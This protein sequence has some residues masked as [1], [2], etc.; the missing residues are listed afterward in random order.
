MTT[1]V[2]A[3]DRR[4]VL[5]IL[6]SMLK[7]QGFVV[8]VAADGRNVLDICSREQVDAVIMDMNMP[9]MDG[10]EATET[11]KASKATQSIPVIICTAHALPWDRK[12]AMECGCNAFMD[13]PVRLEELLKLLRHLLSEAA[14]KT[15]DSHDRD[16]ADDTTVLVHANRGV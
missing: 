3:D 12:R 13:K 16:G 9:E 1:I 8:K 10:C 5:T 14:A 4:D 2:V 6:E 15:G 11:L 7:R